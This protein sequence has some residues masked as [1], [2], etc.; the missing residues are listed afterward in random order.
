MG[1]LFTFGCSFTYYEWPTWANI[2]AVD[3]QKELYN[4][5]VAGIGNVGINQRILEADCKFKFT[6]NDEIMIMWTS[7]CRDD[8]LLEFDY[9]AGG[10]IFNRPLPIRWYKENWSYLDTVV[11]NSNAIIYTDMA[12]KQNISWQGTAFDTDFVESG[13]LPSDRLVGDLTFVKKIKKMYKTKMPKLNTINFTERG[14]KKS[15]GILPDSHP[16]VIDHMN[17]VLNNICDLKSETIELCHSLQKS[18]KTTLIEKRR[19]SN[20]KPVIDD[21]I[22]NE[23]ADNFFKY[24]SYEPLNARI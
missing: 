9:T 20:T 8:K 1:R 3:K 6:P 4:L 24:N 12:Y 5:G 2:I 15:F 10:S 16:D 22:K 19:F 17:I 14:N 21:I 18:I 7:W 23:F 11:K 13:I